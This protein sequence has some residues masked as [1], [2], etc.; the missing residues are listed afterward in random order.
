VETSDGGGQT[1]D[2]GTVLYATE[3]PVA[4]I[5]LNRPDKRNAQNTAL[6]E[7]LDRALDLADA[8]D[9]VRVV[10]LAAAGDH[11]SSGHDL[12]GVV[13]ESQADEWRHARETAEGKL[14]HEE[15]MYYDKT[16]RIRDFRKPT[17]AAVQGACVAAGVMTALACDLVVAA[18]DAW[19]ANP[20]GRMSGVGVEVLVEPY[21]MGFRQAKDFLLT[22]RKVG[23]EE[24]LQL[25]MV[26][27]VV[28]RADLATAAADLARTVAKVPSITAQMIKRS[29]NDAEDLT[30]QRQAWRN[31]FMIHQ[32][33]SNT[34]TALDL[35][36]ARRQKTSMKEIVAERDAE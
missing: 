8:D 11:F 14:R 21:A 19:F 34:K 26:N 17:I 15:V 36:E 7:D 33:T 22:G 20:V 13:D 35:L 3:G 32:Y 28:P 5:T 31:H 30:G 24:A 4:T 2:L 1:K 16:V 12:S 27:R 25:G 9:D 10:V 6:L 29:L 23:A 18:D